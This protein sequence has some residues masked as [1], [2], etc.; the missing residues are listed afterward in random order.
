MKKFTFV[1]DYLEVINGD[2]DPNTGKLYDIFSSTPPIVSLARYDVQVLSSMSQATSSGKG[3]TDRQAEL[4]CK[5]I[6]KY[7]KQLEK[8]EIDVAPVESPVFR[9]ALRVIDRRKLADI[10]SSNIILKFPYDTKLIDS[11]RELAKLSEGRWQF[12]SDSKSWRLGITEPNIVAAYGFATNNQF[13]ISTEFKNLYEQVLEC[14][15]VPYKIKLVKNNGSYEITNSTTTLNDYINNWCG[16]HPTNIDLLVDA[17]PILGYTV[18]KEIEG[19]IVNKYSPRIY[20]LMTAQ[21][22][23][24][25]PQADLDVLTDIVQYAETV[26]RFPIYIYEPDLSDRF[27]NRLISV[28]ISE[29]EIYKVR[30]LKKTESQINQ[31]IIYFSKFNA[32]W[33]KPIKLLISTH[34]MMHGGEKSM[35]TQQ[36]EKVV[37]FAAEVYNNKN[38]RRY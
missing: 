15:K 8:L 37:Y 5:I 21:E 25:A 34:G 13:E 3:L 23:K 31:K 20:N 19:D 30:D 33:D 2:R 35:L 16:F 6:L 26:G 28:G 14:E 12:H 7:K 11:I 36:A 18:S 27:Y 1:E 38:I 17:A 24:F 29:N 32:S 4:A 10:D 22:S 9:H